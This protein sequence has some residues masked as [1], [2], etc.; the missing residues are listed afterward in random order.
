MCIYHLYFI[1]SLKLYTLNKLMLS[2]CGFINTFLK[3]LAMFLFYIVQNLNKR[4]FER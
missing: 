2:K 3:R 4:H 1:F